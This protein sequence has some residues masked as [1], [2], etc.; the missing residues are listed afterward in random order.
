MTVPD[1]NPS[2]DSVAS[3]PNDD[4][5]RRIVRTDLGI[6]G[7]TFVTASLLTTVALP[8]VGWWPLPF[9]ALGWGLLTAASDRGRLGLYLLWG[10]GA[11]LV[12]GVVLALAA[13]AD[14]TIGFLPLTLYGLAI[15]SAANRLLFGVA[16]P[17]PA[18]RRRR[19]D[20]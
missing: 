2:T 12:L 3:E 4:L 9:V 13:D 17:V 6:A 1:P 14:W 10:V 11:L 20:G 18:A 8:V 19:E 15:G 16:R 5:N 7:S